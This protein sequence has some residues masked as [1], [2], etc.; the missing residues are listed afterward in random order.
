MQKPNLP[1]VQGSW[2]S[3]ICRR[4]HTK[5]PIGIT[6]KIRFLC[7]SDLLVSFLPKLRILHPNTSRAWN[8]SV[9]WITVFSLEWSISILIFSWFFPLSWDRWTT[10]G[11]LVIG[12]FTTSWTFPCGICLEIQSKALSGLSVMLLLF[13]DWE[14]N[15]KNRNL[16]CLW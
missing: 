11:S 1:H 10:L 6:K 14:P 13:D 2:V 7:F 4:N 8:Q 15:S 9:L 5:S 12:G 3:R 16:F